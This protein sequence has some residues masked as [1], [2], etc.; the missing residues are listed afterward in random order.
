MAQWSGTDNLDDRIEK[1]P[2]WAQRYINSLRKNAEWYKGQ[3][4]LVRDCATDIRWNLRVDD[5][6]GNIPSRACV[7]FTTNGGTLECVI[8]DGHLRIRGAD[9]E[10]P[11]VRSEAYNVIQVDAKK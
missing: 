4:G 1:L 2:K 10:R 5:V 8:R 7:L 11:V 3:L 6:G 9:T